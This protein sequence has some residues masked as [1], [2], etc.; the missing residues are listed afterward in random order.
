MSKRRLR[1]LMMSLGKG[2]GKTSMQSAMM[3]EALR[4]YLQK[5]PGQSI[6][7]HKRPTFTTYE[8]QKEKSIDD[9]N[10]SRTKRLE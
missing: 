1:K 5:H 9:G 7:I 6:K 8:I 10:D 4:R 3:E 2:S